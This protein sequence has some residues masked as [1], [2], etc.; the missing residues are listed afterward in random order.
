MKKKYGILLFVII[1]ISSLF[2]AAQKKPKREPLPACAPAQYDSFSRTPHGPGELFDYKA[3]IWGIYIGNLI[4]WVDEPESRTRL[5]FTM[6]AETNN[7]FSTFKT[8]GYYIFSNTSRSTGLP[9]KTVFYSYGKGKRKITSAVYNRNKNFVYMNYLHN[10]KRYRFRKK[11]QTGTHDMLSMF[12]DFRMRKFEKGKPVCVD[13]IVGKRIWRLELTL[14]GREKIKVPAGTFN[15]YK[16]EGKAVR[17]DKPHSKKYKRKALIW[18][19]ADKK[20]I[21]VKGAT[22]IFLGHVT[23]ELSHYI[24]PR[25]RQKMSKN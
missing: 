1:L 20:R 15:C 25:H 22:K 2:A 5:P 3:Y 16:L 17:K 4:A 14:K 8:F 11:M 6:F 24:P 9:V 23:V 19:T 10:K 18:I 7:F 13:Y 12:I 21:I